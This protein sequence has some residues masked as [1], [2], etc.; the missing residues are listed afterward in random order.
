MTLEVCLEYIPHSVICLTPGD[1][2][3][4]DISLNVIADNL[5]GAS[6]G[7]S[8]VDILEVDAVAR[9]TR[10]ACEISDDLAI[11]SATCSI[12]VQKLDV[13]DVHFGRVSG[14]CRIVDVEIAL[15]QDDGSIGV[16]NVDVLVSYVVDVA[17]SDVRTSPCLETSA[18]LSVEK[19]NVL[20]P[21]IGDEVF[22]AGVLS[23]GAHRD[24][25]CSV[26]PEIPDHQESV[27]FTR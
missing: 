18:V 11:L 27:K 24:T 1:A 13:G 10:T 22:D 6:G 19:G 9:R 14:T 21:G 5:R 7:A 12:D 25:M 2:V 4:P 8:N 26:T 16:L 23:D 20:N 17:I 15:V 3:H